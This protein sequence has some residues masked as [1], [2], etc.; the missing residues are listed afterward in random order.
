MQADTG[1]WVPYAAREF[2][3][4]HGTEV[5]QTLLD[6]VAEHPA[7]IEGMTVEVG[8]QR[9]DDSEAGTSPGPA[10]AAR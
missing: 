2:L 3:A 9:N 8:P 10:T 1:G 6:A 7:Q 5:D 4:R